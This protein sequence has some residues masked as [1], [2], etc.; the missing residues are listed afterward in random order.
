MQLYEG[1]IKSWKTDKGFG[2]IQPNDKGKD[3]FIHIRDLKHSNYQPQLGDDICYKVVAE[4]NG[5]IRAYDAC[6]KGQEI[7]QLYR[8]KRFRK[9]Q[10]QKQKTIWQF[11][12]GMLLVSVIASIP[13]IFSAFLIKVEHNL[14]PFFTY[15][16]MS[17]SAFI[18]Y[19]IDKTKA[20]KNEW[21]ISESTLHL[22]EL[23]GGWPGAL[24][25]QQAIR[26]KNKKISFQITI[27]IIVIIHLVIWLDIVFFKSS[28]IDAFYKYFVS[29][30]SINAR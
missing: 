7:S 19:A 22:F 1:I 30:D 21:R 13:F 24:I 27:W 6:I 3:I 11:R 28:N 25:T 17:L 18:V 10:P 9:N 14:I 16:L 20:H 15:L 5:K 26:H 29:L 4:K 23:F 8:K 12:L 2:F